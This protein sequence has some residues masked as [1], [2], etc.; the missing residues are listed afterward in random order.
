ME[1]LPQHLYYCKVCMRNFMEPE[2]AEHVQTCH[3]LMVFQ[4][5]FTPGSNGITIM[6][7][8]KFWDYLGI[9]KMACNLTARSANFL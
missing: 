4:P 5:R 2:V 1:D 8:N 7:G 6:N 9:P 3:K